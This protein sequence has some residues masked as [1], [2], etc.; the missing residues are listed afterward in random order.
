MSRR[1]LSDEKGKGFMIPFDTVQ[2]GELMGNPE[3]CAEVS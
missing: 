2:R 3:A 1:G